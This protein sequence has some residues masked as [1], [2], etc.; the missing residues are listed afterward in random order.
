MA[1]GRL[2]TWALAA[3]RC[4]LQL[5]IHAIGDRATHEVL[6][7][8]EEIVRV[9]RPWD[10]RLRME[11]AQHM[12]PAD[13][14]RMAALGVIASVQ[15]YHC[16]DDGSWAESRIGPERAR[17]TYPFRSFLE[18]G[19]PLCFGSDWTVA[20]LDPILGIHAAVTRATLDGK[21]PGGWIPEQRLTVEQ[22]VRCYTLAGAYASFEEN[23]KG[24]LSPGKW[25]D[26]VVLD[27]DLFAIDPERI[28][29]VKVARTILGAETIYEAGA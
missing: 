10:R 15:P 7:L 6:D 3:D 23:C 20:P 25:A 11:H 17:T 26:M 27:Q 29:E 19:V 12:L 14:R 2:R 18:A 5:S 4:G 22:A 1:D 9:N 8:F 13:I 21:H 28:P 16:I 24:S